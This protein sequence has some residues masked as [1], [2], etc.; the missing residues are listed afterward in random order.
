MI[1]IHPLLSARRGGRF[2]VSPSLPGPSRASFH[3]LR[4]PLIYHY[5]C[6]QLSTYVISGCCTALYIHYIWPG[7]SRIPRPF[8]DADNDTFDLL[9]WIMMCIFEHLVVSMDP[10]WMGDIY[11]LGCVTLLG[12]LKGKLNI[13]SPNTGN[14]ST[15]GTSSVIHVQ[16]FLFSKSMFKCIWWHLNI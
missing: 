10:H 12:T 15:H 7:N 13:P 8:V 16:M 3:F 9:G 1:Y 5:H 14:C 6:Q 11:R 4:L 2:E